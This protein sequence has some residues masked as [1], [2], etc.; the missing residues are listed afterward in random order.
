MIML[1]KKMN[2][3]ANFVAWFFV[4]VV[5]M[6]FSVF[7]L[8]LNMAWEKIEAPL[9]ET[10]Q[11]QMPDDSPVNISETL[12][13][14]GDTTQNFSAMIAFL[15]I[16]LFA[17]VLL[18]AGAMLKSPVMI[19][20]GLIVLGVLILVAVV[21]S[22]V[23]IEIK[24]SGSFDSVKDNLTVQNTVMNYLPAIVWTL[25]FGVVVFILYGRSTGGS[26]GA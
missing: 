17:F 23:Y 9:D 15:I 21:F 8:V 4:I 13:S 25:A 10:L 19:I 26:S 14:V 24:D 7:A 6:A 16:G 20:I 3:K 11:E 5:L 22:N 1:N 2:K 18:T 12:G